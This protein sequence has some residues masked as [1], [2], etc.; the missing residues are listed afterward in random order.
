MATKKQ[1]AGSTA[2]ASFIAIVILLPFLIVAIF[3]YLMLKRSFIN[4]KN[5]VRI[6]DITR[7]FNRIIPGLS[8]VTI[9]II[10]TY[11]FHQI[12]ID[13]HYS[14]AI[15]SSTIAVIAFIY[16]LTAWRTASA[17]ASGLIGVVIDSDDA[18]L[19]FPTD[20]V[21]RSFS[22]NVIMNAIIPASR[23]ILT[24]NRIQTYNRQAGKTLIIHGDFGSRAITFSDKLRRD[25]LISLIS[26]Y[27]R[28]SDS[29][30]SGEGDYV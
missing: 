29:E 7:A 11:S 19:N 1:D 12:Y 9:I 20:G 15:L 6:V 26:G 28:F 13:Q 23:E 2:I 4:N 24:L 8:I 21:L 27:R 30:Y 22:F 17:F 5:V 16:I 18:T 10:V 14:D 25:Q 3:K